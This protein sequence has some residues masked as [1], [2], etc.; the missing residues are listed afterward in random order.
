M[1]ELLLESPSGSFLQE[2]AVGHMLPEPDPYAGYY[3]EVI[4]SLARRARPQTLR[5]LVL[6]DTQD[7]ERIREINIGSLEP[8]YPAF[9][10]LRRL[11]IHGRL[12]DL[13]D[14]ALPELRELAVISGALQAPTLETIREGH[15]PE[16]KRLVLWLGS[17]AGA[18]GEEGAPRWAPVSLSD[19][20]TFLTS[21]RFPKLKHLALM[22][23]EFSD[24]LCELLTS[25]PMVRQLESLGL[26]MGTLTRTGAEALHEKRDAL[27]GLRFLN[28][29]DNYLDDAGQDLVRGLARVVRTGIQQLPAGPYV[30]SINRDPWGQARG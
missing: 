28:V 11:A 19:L 20:E 9:P 26:A 22:Q 3:Q 25:T 18:R 24:E 4:D 12:V 13:G 8:L 6:G 16:L 15:L 14:L 30:A 23:C 2:L 29:N 27:S 10:E 7:L 1:T 21:D 5:G 17:S